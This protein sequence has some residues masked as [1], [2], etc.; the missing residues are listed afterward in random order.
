VTTPFVDLDE[1]GLREGL[2]QTTRLAVAPPYRAQVAENLRV[3]QRH[4]RIV[5]AALRTAGD[6]GAVAGPFEP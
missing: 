4:A 3:L 5:A 2:E 1:T 6:P